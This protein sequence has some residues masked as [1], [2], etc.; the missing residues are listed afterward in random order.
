ML[1]V[2]EGSPNFEVKSPLACGGYFIWI[3]LA[4]NINI[5]KVK[6]QLAEDNIVAPFGE[7]FV[8]ESDREKQ[9]F[10]YLKRRIRLGFS[11]LEED[12]LVEGS[13]KVRAAIDGAVDNSAKF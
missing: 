13:K 4:D 10:E 2:L 7:I 5:A 1:S 12:V 3:K 8:Q 9:E 11:F 6:S